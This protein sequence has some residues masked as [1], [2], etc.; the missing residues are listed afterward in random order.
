M[1]GPGNEEE[2]VGNQEWE[3]TIVPYSHSQVSKLLSVELASA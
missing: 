3:V 2:F 1:F